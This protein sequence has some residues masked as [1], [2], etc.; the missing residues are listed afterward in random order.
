M[1]SQPP[2]AGMLPL[3]AKRRASLL[4]FYS[5]SFP[6]ESTGHSGDNLDFM[7]A[8]VLNKLQLAALQARQPHST[9]TI[10]LTT[11]E[12]SLILHTHLDLQRQAVLVSR[13]EEVKERMGFA[14]TEAL[15]EAMRVIGEYRASQPPECKV[16][17]RELDQ[18]KRMYLTAEKEMSKLMGYW[19]E[20]SKLAAKAENI[21][22]EI[23]SLY[24]SHMSICGIAFVNELYQLVCEM[25]KSWRSTPEKEKKNRI[26]SAIKSLL[27]DRERARQERS[28]LEQKLTTKDKIIGDHRDKINRLRGDADQSHQRYKEDLGKVQAKLDAEHSKILEQERQLEDKWS[29]KVQ[30]RNGKISRLQTEVESLKQELKLRQQSS[31][32]TSADSNGGKPTYADLVKENASLGKESTSLKKKFDLARKHLEDGSTKYKAPKVDKEILETKLNDQLVGA[33][34]QQKVILSL[35]SSDEVVKDR[36]Q[37]AVLQK[38]QEKDAEIAVLKEEIEKLSQQRRIDMSL[39]GDLNRELRDLQEGCEV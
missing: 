17:R 14:N 38:S 29:S 3:D 7:A 11:N 32:P 24:E 36:I 35:R 23:G 30:K 8:E 10:T 12:A 13:Q 37:K 19:E 25:D 15:E 27:K 5:R 4:D 22:H 2:K 16:T 34:S 18:Y 6:I 39:N 20:T 31:C 33:A 21:A 26:N 28:S 9:Y 1:A